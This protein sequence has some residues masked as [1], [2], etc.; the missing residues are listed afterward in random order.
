MMRNKCKSHQEK[1]QHFF[2][3]KIKEAFEEKLFAT[4]QIPVSFT[5]Q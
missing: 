3:F 5:K 4:N 1:K 2:T